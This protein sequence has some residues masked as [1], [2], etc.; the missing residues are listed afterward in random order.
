VKHY[1]TT[2]SIKNYH[3]TNTNLGEVT[4]LTIFSPAPYFYSPAGVLAWIWSP[5]KRTTF[6]HIW[7]ESFKASWSFISPPLL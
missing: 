2:L 6:Q 1:G 7:L 3:V 5:E 4:F